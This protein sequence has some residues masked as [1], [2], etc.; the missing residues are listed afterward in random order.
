MALGVAVVTQDHG[1]P[2]SMSRLWF[3]SERSAGLRFGR[4][5]RI[6][7]ALALVTTAA[8]GSISGSG[9]TGSAEQRSG[10]CWVWRTGPGRDTALHLNR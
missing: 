7:A 9:P 4:L 6:A 2:P 5:G 8:C 3:E 10:A 1:F